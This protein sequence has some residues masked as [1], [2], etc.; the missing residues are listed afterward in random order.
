MA[1]HGGYSGL[2]MDAH[3]V[4]G[5]WHRIMAREVMAFMIRGGE[6]AWRR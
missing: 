1:M 5:G 4:G 6:D 2:I 3:H